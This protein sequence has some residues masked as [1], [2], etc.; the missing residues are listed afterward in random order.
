MSSK[1]Y[2]YFPRSVSWQVANLLNPSLNS[3][4]TGP[5]S[6]THESNHHN[7]TSRNT[8]QR[9]VA[10]GVYGSRTV[11]PTGDGITTVSGCLTENN[12]NIVRPGTTMDKSG[13]GPPS[14]PLTT[15]YRLV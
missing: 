10:T 6:S 12:T 4:E 1:H 15:A 13:T 7:H 5:P 2:N 8:S 3:S 14:S 11:A 9:P